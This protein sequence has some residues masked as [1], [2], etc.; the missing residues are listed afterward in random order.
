MTNYRVASKYRVEIFRHG[1]FK[2]S[3][4]FKAAEAAVDFANMWHDDHYDED[5]WDVQIIAP[6]GAVHQT[7]INGNE[8]TRS[9]S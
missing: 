7:N 6:D 2:K 5:G 1:N 8:S 3:R 4:T 9:F